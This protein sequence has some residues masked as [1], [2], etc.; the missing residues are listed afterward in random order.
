[1]TFRDLPSI[2]HVYQARA[3]V[4]DIAR[5]IEANSDEDFRSAVAVRVKHLDRAGVIGFVGLLFKAKF[6]DR[7]AIVVEE[8]RRYAGQL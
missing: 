4:H 5:Q 3:A 6:E 1:M 7:S 2:E 8:L